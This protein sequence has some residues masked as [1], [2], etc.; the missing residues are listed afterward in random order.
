MQD[1]FELARRNITPS[2]IMQFFT[3][4]PQEVK[5]DELWTTNPL[6]ADKSIG[7]FHVN[8]TTGYWVDHADGSG[9][10]FIDLFAKYNN[11]TTLEAAKKIA[12]IQEVQTEY[13]TK[14]HL[15]YLNKYMKSSFLTE[16]HGQP[17]MGWKY[18]DSN[19]VWLCVIRYEKDGKKSI[20][21]FTIVDG[22]IKAANNYKENRKL[23][24]INKLKKGDKVLIVEGEKCA[25]VKV[26]GYTVLTWLGGCDQVKKTNF[27]VLK[28]YDVTI[29]HDNDEPGEKARDYIKTQLPEAKLMKIENKKEK[30]DIADAEQE[31]INIVEFIKNNIIVEEKEPET[32]S[33]RFL[34]Y[35]DTHH[36]FLSYRSNTIE[37]IAKGSIA[38]MRLLELASLSY[39]MYKYPAS[40]KGGDGVDWT[41]AQDDII[42][43]SSKC[44]FF[45]HMKVRGVG[46]WKEGKDI[47]INDGNKCYDENGNRSDLKN[48]VNFYVRSNKI[49]NS[50]DMNNL[51]T[52]D[53]AKDLYHLIESQEFETTLDVFSLMGWS[54][55]SPFAGILAWRPHIWLTGESGG[56][57]SFILENIVIP[58]VGTYSFTGNGSDTVPGIMR[59]VEKDPIPVIKDEMEVSE[60][61]LDGRQKIEK[62]LE[63]MRNASCDSSAKTT[64]ARAG[65]GTDTY[66]VR[67]CFCFASIMSGTTKESQENRIAMCRLK[68]VEDVKRKIENTKKYSHVMMNYDKYRNR[69]MSEIHNVIENITIIKKIIIKVTGNMRM[70][71]VYAPLI[72]AVYA[73]MTGGVCEGEKLLETEVVCEKLFKHIVG[74]ENMRDENRVL[75][76][77]FEHIVRE[78]YESYSIG[79]M[80]NNE[81]IGN[82]TNYILERHGIKKMEFDG[83]LYLIICKNHTQIS[84]ILKNTN[85]NV[86]YHDVLKRHSGYAFEKKIRFEGIPKYAIGLK[87]SAL[88]FSEVDL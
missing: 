20:I 33:F 43:T 34:G 85:Y 5:S 9:G 53:E 24:N 79:G 52:N 30:W 27:K 17:C 48:A 28:N 47:V 59:S 81:F 74:K 54:L 19:G 68:K 21:P 71:E 46:I 22:K 76:V 82:E 57:K 86:K 12:G 3:G 87:W 10:D 72:S 65:G 32:E 78:G 69:M 35:D 45:D 70:A 4:R 62:M 44:G 61:N 15:E 41:I 80:L 66:I 6:R 84:G 67:S 23:Y 58:L 14:N 7:S 8:L 77:I 40:S 60:L 88:P 39:W 1:A 49:M 56:G 37:K 18:E 75:D 16:K 13:F 42:N 51:A 55:I 73:V 31:G 25:S 50:Y 64:M 83:E 26:E 38:K 36:Y 29:W 11:I 63:M 2:Y